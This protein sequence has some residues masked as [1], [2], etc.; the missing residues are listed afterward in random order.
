MRAK[1]LWARVV[2]AL[3]APAALAGLAAACAGG[4]AIFNVD[5]ESF[6]KGT[7]KD[8]VPYTLPLPV[9]VDTT[10][11]PQLLRLLGAGS[12]V[13]DSVV[14]AGAANILN[15]S[16]SGTLAFKLYLAADS[17]GTRLPSALALSVPAK[18]VSGST[19][20]PDAISCPPRPA[21]CLLF[22]SAD[23]LFTRDSVWVRVA[24]TASNT[25]AGTFA[26]KLALTSLL[27][28]VVLNAKLF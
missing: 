21:S 17:A 19:P 25:G 26:G 2:A 16:G 20:I 27:L 23:S 11:P 7:G 3:A 4:H 18:A 9:T 5:V 13:V 22:S 6:L 1:W 14:I 8:M 12:S 10:S 24:V 28:T 15:Q